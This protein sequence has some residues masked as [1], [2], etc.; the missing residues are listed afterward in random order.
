M[1]YREREASILASRVSLR[2]CYFNFRSKPLVAPSLE[3]PENAM[4]QELLQELASRPN[5]GKGMLR[6]HK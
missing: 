3:I 5:I 4:H 6:T 1:L 2:Y